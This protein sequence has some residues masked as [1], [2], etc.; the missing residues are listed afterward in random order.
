MKATK[1]MIWDWDIINDRI[2]RSDSFKKIFGYG[3]SKLPS[4][5]KFWFEKIVEKDRKRVRQSLKTA[6]DD[7]NIRKWREEYCFLKNDREEAHVIDRGYILRDNHG[8][9][10]RMVG[11]VLDVT[12]SRQ[13]LR[14]IQKQNKILKEVAW[15]QAHVVRAPLARLKGLLDL[16]EQ[17]SYE[18]WSREELVGLIR[19]SAEEVDEII[20]KIIR[21]TE[22]IG[23]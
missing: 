9:A 17:E 7:P 3:T 4:V 12:E 6:L 5:E 2:K 19:S 21:K 13:M 11:A 23:N 15:E 8:K 20:E 16:L 22:K 14:E 1:E 10:I 18:E